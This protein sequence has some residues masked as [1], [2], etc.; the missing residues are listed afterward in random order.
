VAFGWR[1][2]EA[3]CSSGGKGAGECIPYEKSWRATS[4]KT[5]HKLVVHNLQNLA[6][7]AL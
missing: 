1:I 2:C 6:F 3:G 4:L 5:I 7:T